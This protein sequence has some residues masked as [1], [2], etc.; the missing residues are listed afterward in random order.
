VQVLSLDELDRL[1]RDGT[2]DKWLTGLGEY[3]AGA[4]K[5]PSPVDPA[6]YYT[7]DLFLQASE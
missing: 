4:G 1:T 2:I 3:F 5:L 7:G 6:Q